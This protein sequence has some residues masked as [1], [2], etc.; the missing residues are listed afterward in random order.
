[1][2]TIIVTGA[3]SGIGKEATLILAE[4]GHRVL[5]LCRDSEKSARVFEEI[6][7][8]T[9][10]ESV[11]LIPV[12]LSS[13]DSI[14]AAALDIKSR[15]SAIDVLVNNAG[16]YVPKRE[17]TADG[18]E[19]NFAVNYLAPFLLS[20]LLL[21]TLEASGNGR[22]INVVS[23]LYEKGVVDLE[24]LM[25]ERSY[26]VGRAYAGSKMACVLFTIELARRTQ[27]RGVTVNALHPG[28]LAT[29][30]MRH[31]PAIVAKLF[32]LMLEKAERGGERIAALAT[33]EAV[34]GVSGTYFFKSETRALKI[35]DRESGKSEALW[36]ASEELTGMLD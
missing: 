13:G 7:A 36:R 34:Q 21:T 15:H 6:V 4:A 30:M 25:S 12:D 8:R 9:G 24:D 2:K 1:M 27:K 3:N 35:S 19:M 31:Y 23:A 5:M 33:S 22:I 10:N 11:S 14:R 26:K 28:V 17:E 18:I 16:V 32:G 20:H 29:G